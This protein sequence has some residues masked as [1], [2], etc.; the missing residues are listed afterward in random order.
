M[1]KMLKSI[2]TRLGENN[3]AAYSVM[4]IAVFKGILRPTFTMADKKTDKKT[5]KYAATREGLTEG[6]AF[7]S[8]LAVDKL[9]E[10]LAKPLTKKCPEKLGKVKSGLG[11]L[12]VC[13]SALLVIPAVC[14]VAIKPVMNK[15]TK[16]D[17]KPS[18]NT[19]PVQKTQTHIYPMPV[20]SSSSRMKVG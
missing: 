12:G 20:S 3:K 9:I 5:K 6:I 17:N 4:L 11:F 16:N 14:N 10:P 8:Y 2:F 15:I 7:L 18:T 13:A 19:L 1:E